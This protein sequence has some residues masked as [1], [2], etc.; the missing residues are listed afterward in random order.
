M[1]IRHS[2]PRRLTQEISRYVFEQTSERGTRAFD[3]ISY[4]SRLGDDLRNW[5]LFEPVTHAQVKVFVAEGRELPIE[6]QHPDFRR[7]LE[8]LGIRL[9]DTASAPW[10]QSP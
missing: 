8:L 1:A 9:L 3:G 10:R 4:L 5:A 6:P 7:A 2:A